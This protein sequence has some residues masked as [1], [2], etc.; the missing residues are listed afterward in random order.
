MGLSCWQFSVCQEAGCRDGADTLESL[1]HVL[2]TNAT[3]PTVIN[4]TG[5]YLCCSSSTTKP[6]GTILH[7]S[8][9]DGA[10]C[11]QSKYRVFFLT[12]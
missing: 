4:I 11:C 2:T 7:I 6:S 1:D 10:D 5:R 8:N 12:T 9:C 3:E